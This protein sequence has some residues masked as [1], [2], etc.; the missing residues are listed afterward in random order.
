MKTILSSL[1]LLAV[2]TLLTGGVYPVAVTVIAHI[3]FSKA[4]AGS[5]IQRNG[6]IAGSELLAQKAEDPRY[7][8]PRPSAADYA[9]VASGAS[10]QGPT[11]ESLR[12]SI[13]ERRLKYGNDAPADL[14][15]TSGS[16]LDPHLTPAAAKSEAPRVAAARHMSLDKL[17]AMIDQFTEGPQF[18][19]FGESRVNVLKLNLALDARS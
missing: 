7:F 6:D 15:T 18:G 16:G 14:L 10:N 11:S 9:T 19:V 13:A 12:K 4:A 17:N 3:A 5:L 8:W 1:R 2:L